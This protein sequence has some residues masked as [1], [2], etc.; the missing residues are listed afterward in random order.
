MATVAESR[1]RTV[2]GVAFPV[3]GVWALDPAHTSVEFQAS[4]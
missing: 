1:E 4:T 3:A 2:D